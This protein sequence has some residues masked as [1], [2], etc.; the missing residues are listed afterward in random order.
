MQA[1]EL[2]GKEI[3]R[4]DRQ[5]IM[6]GF[7]EEG[8][9]KLKNTKVFVA[10]CGGLGSPIAEYMAVAGFGN[11]VIAD[12][13]TVDLSNLNRQI[14]H[15]EKDV[16]VSKVVSGHEKL[17]Q[18]NR[19]I[20]IEAFN[21]RIDENNVYDLT[22]DCDIIMDAMDNF[23]TRY[24]LNRASIEHDIPLIYAS[25]W[26]MEGRLTTIIPGSTPCIECIFPKAPPNEIF[27]ILGATAG[28]IGALQVTEA[29]KVILG[30][31]EPLAG[32]LLVYDGEYMEFHEL[33]ICKNPVCPVCGKK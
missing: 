20:N 27:P 22:R 8:Q 7:G 13:D 16:G 11:I 18:M 31:G 25:V 2:S 6:R 4:Y 10:G 1:G 26:G 9:K 12:M 5:I 21:G 33:K 30:I 24:L 28:V 32:R 29:V 14:L 23:E 17:T 3:K 19:D 15:W